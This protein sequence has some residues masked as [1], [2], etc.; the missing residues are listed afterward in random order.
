M[1]KEK[2]GRPTYRPGWRSLH[3]PVREYLCLTLQYE[4]RHKYKFDHTLYLGRRCMGHANIS[5]YTV[6]HNCPPVQCATTI[7]HGDIGAAVEFRGTT[8][9]FLWYYVV[10]NK[11]HSTTVQCGVQ[12]DGG[13]GTVR[14]TT[15]S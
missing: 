2:L 6:L 15:V 14:G 7:H 12:D 5:N 13:G 8:L 3:W 9:S 10:Q 1:Q 4:Y 11:A